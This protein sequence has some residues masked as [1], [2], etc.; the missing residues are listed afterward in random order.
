MP[1]DAM[2]APETSATISARYLANRRDRGVICIA[3]PGPR[4]TASPRG[5]CGALLLRRH[6]VL[7]GR[8]KGPVVRHVPADDLVAVGFMALE[9]KAVG[10]RCSCDADLIRALDRPGAWDTLTSLDQDPRTIGA[11]MG[12]KG[13][14]ASV[15]AAER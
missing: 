12:H 9:T 11:K 6:A 13:I 5:N 3:P 10:A 15:F 2:R 14:P 4:L 8:L 1:L 7:D